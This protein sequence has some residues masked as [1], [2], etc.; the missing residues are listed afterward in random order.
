MIDNF[1]KQ[2]NVFA[3]NVV[4]HYIVLWEVFLGFILFCVVFSV[5]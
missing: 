1:K 2:H 3:D 4:L 5:I